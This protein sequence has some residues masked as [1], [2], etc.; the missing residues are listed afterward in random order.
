MAEER[1][2]V[3]QR[4]VLRPNTR[5]RLL[6][7]FYLRFP[8]AG[9][10][11]TRAVLRRPPSSPIRRVIT[12]LVV[13]WALEAANR[14]DFEAAFCLLPPDYETYPPPDIVGLGFES[15]YR[16]RDERVQLQQQWMDELG[17]FEQEAKEV[18]DSGDHIVVLGWMRGTGLGSG[19]EFESEVSYAIEIRDGRLA[20]EH[21]FPSH[22]EALEIA[23]LSADRA[24]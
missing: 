10:R 22:G 3:C 4:I 11:L 6:E 23:G 13:R 21:F 2:V 18:I 9:E 15:V 7:R 19:A 16:G 8:S 14:L 17:D 20:R 1:E 5:R 24:P 12:R